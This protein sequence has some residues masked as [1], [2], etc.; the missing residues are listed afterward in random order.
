VAGCFLNINR[1]TIHAMNSAYIIFT[2][3]YQWRDALMDIAALK[4]A[5][6]DETFTELESFI[7]D[8]KGQRD[9]AI[10]EQINKRKSMKLELEGLKGL[11]E[12]QV[13]LLE[14]LGIDSIEDVDSLPDVAGMAEAN[15]QVEAKVKRLERVNGEL[16]AEVGALK[17]DKRNMHRDI[18]LSKAL[19]PHDFI[20]SDIFAKG[21][22][23]D[24]VWEGDDL[25]F[26]TEDGNLVS[27]KDGVAGIAK[28]RPELLKP[29]GAGGA[30]VRS[31]NAGSTAGQTTMTR[32]EFEAL[33]PAKKMEVSKDGV[34]LQ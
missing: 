7:G 29:T 18:T 25:L 4:E 1:T 13:T 28:S 20:A 33:P 19:E 8:L 3:K 9:N 11:K 27:V 30:G 24:L 10:D 23:D 12:A 17:G 16:G 15:K 5:L 32:A 34:T 6:G 2:G 14:R 21:I 31:S 22:K 26:K